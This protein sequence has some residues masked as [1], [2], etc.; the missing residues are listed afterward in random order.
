MLQQRDSAARKLFLKSSRAS[1]R[2]LLLTPESWLLNP[3]F[4]PVS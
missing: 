1:A 4:I 2:G 3:V